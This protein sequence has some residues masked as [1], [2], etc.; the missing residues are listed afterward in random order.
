MPYLDF[1]KARRV[2][3]VIKKEQEKRAIELLKIAPTCFKLPD[4]IVKEQP[5]TQFLKEVKHIAKGRLFYTRN[6]N[7]FVNNKIMLSSLASWLVDYICYTIEFDSNLV[8]LNVDDI[9]LIINKKPRTIYD[10]IQELDD[11]NI[12]KKTDI[13]KTYVINHNV[14]FKGDM[15]EFLYNYNELYGKGKA[16]LG[17]QLFDDVDYINGKIKNRR[18]LKIKHIVYGKSESAD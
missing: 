3:D 12:I 10:A 6:Q 9:S 13:N 5:L 1:N 16:P 8:K 15:Q 2:K 14:I 7:Y 4:I 18:E 17:D 11:N